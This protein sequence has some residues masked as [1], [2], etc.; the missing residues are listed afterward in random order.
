MIE[1]Y[2]GDCLDVVSGWGDASVDL[3]F[4]DPPF[5]IGKN[6]GASSTDRKGDYVDW[7]RKWI[8]ECFR[9]LKPTGVFYLKT[10]SKHLDWK[11]PMMAEH[12]VF[13]SLIIWRNVSAARDVRR[14]WNSFEPILCYGRTPDYK[15]NRYAEQRETGRL[16]YWASGRNERRKGQIMD[17]WD[18]ISPVYAGSI[19]HDEAVLKPGTRRKEHP[20]QMPTGLATRAISFSSDPGDMVVDIFNGSGTTGVAA[21]QLGRRYRGIDINP[22]YIELSRHRLRQEVLAIDA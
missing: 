17:Y 11:M 22:D 6:Y 2:A 9:L 12:G 15:F 1:L 16:N 7:C 14:F 5:N 8:S 20:C 21:K 4:T 3:I 18:D 19:V 10:L 13:I